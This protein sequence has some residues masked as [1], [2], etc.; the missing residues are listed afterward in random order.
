MA[1]RVAINGTVIFV[2]FNAGYNDMLENWAWHVQA[3]GLGGH[4]IIFAADQTALAFATSKWP[5]QAVLL[6]FSGQFGQEEKIT[7]GKF[8]QAVEKFSQAVGKFSQA[9]GKVSQA[10]GKFSQ[11]VGKFSQAVGKFSQAVGKFSQAVGKFSQAVGKFSQ[12]VG[13]FSQAVGKF[14][15]AVGKFS[16]AVEKFS[17]AVGKFSQAV[18]KFSQAVGKFSQAVGKFSQAVGKFSQAVGK[19]T[20]GKFS[21]A[22]EK[23]SQAV[24]KFSQAVG[25]VSQAVGKFSQAVGKFSQAVGKFSQAVGKF[26]QAVGKFSQAVGKFSQA[27]GKFSQAVGKFSQAVGKFSQAVEKFS[28]AVG[29]FSQAVGK[30]SQAVGK[31]SQAVGKFSRSIV[32]PWVQQP[33]SSPS[34]LHVHPTSLLPLTLFPSSPFL[35]H[36]RSTSGRSIVY[37]WAVASSIPGFSNH[38]LPFPAQVP[39]ANASRV[40]SALPALLAAQL[41]QAEQ[42]TIISD[43]S[44]VWLK[45]PFPFFSPDYNLILPSFRDQRKAAEIGAGPQEAS[46]SSGSSSDGSGSGPSLWFRFGKLRTTGLQACM[47]R[48]IAHMVKEENQK[49]GA[50]VGV[51]PVPLFPPG[52]LAVGNREWFEAQRERLVAVHNNCGMESKHKAKCFRSMKLWLIDE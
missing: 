29:K 31:F 28:Q 45:D 35:P 34:G 15:Q 44:T 18:G 19:F 3:V 13:K 16:Q 10:V 22:V 20:V 4:F 26:S 46:A 21:E 7:V 33:I 47:N 17:Q 27:V 14:S 8:S 11:A 51:L 43:V 30:F 41:M 36:T 24:G 39:S 38:L 32:Y 1:N 25:K 52:W 42:S 48:A 50:S 37:L 40:C 23:F 6:P 5:G 9:V 49:D 2:Y 12:A